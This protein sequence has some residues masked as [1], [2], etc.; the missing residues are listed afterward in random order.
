MKPTALVAA[1]LIL[2]AMP[3]GMA[4]AQISL[5]PAAEEGS[6]AVSYP[7]DGT[8]L[9]WKE[10]QQVQQYIAA[11]PNVFN[12]M[13][14]RKP[15]RWG[16]TVGT[17]RSWW[18]MDFQTS[19]NYQVASTCRAVG[20]NC[21]IFVEETQWGS[22]V[23]Q[24][25]VDSIRVAFDLRTPANA[26]KGVYQ[27]DVDA[28]GNPPDVDSDPKI[29]LLLLDIKDGYTGTG[30][31]IMGYFYSANEL[32]GG[33]SN[34]AEI[35]FLDV[36]PL[37]LSTA[38][39]LQGGMSTTAHEFQHMIHWNYNK[40]GDTF[41]NEGCSLLA[42]VNCGY[43]LYDQSGYIKETN[44]Y[45]FDWRTNDNTLV[46]HDYSRAA[47][48]FLYI[49]DQLGISFFKTLVSTAFTG[50]GRLDAAFSTFGT[51]LRFGDV[52]QNWLIANI[53]NDRSVD[54]KYGYLYP[55]VPKVAGTIYANPN[56]MVSAKNVANLG[57]EFPVFKY[58]SG[59]SINFST[60][61]AAVVV[62]AVE[63]GAAPTSTR[64]LNVTPGTLFTE[65][66]YGTTYPEVDFVVV[67]TDQYQ[68]YTYS[69]N[70]TGT[71]NSVELKW[72]LA[73]PAGYLKLSNSDTLCVTFDGLPGFKLD[74]IRV[75][76]RRAGSISGGIWRYSG[77]IGAPLGA[78]LA[79]PITATSD[80][81]PTVVDSSGPFPYPIPYP[82]WRLVDLRS[83]SIDAAS[84]FAAA[85]VITSTSV[86]IVV[87]KNPGSA[88]VH[89]V[90]Y[91]STLTPPGWYILTPPSGGDSIWAYGIRAYVS[92]RTTGVTEA[93]ELL[94]SALSVGQNYPNPF[95]PSTTIEYT[96]PKP[97]AVTI[98]VFD[99]L[100]RQIRL[101]ASGEQS[102]GRH[103]VVW[104][105][106]DNHGVD[107]MSGVYYY[108]VETA[109]GSISRK[110]MLVR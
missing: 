30:G 15:N 85:F 103:S 32:T 102:A 31:Y 56:E 94:P 105:G 84:P 5:A 43:P 97:G 19:T 108:R 73:E 22:R 75:A 33:Q 26:S 98:R 58:G 106:R 92:L 34:M 48:F 90:T 82:G 61:N 79:V 45:L 50:V 99:M 37:D 91:R 54:P 29:I 38:S 2:V 66:G 47:R 64:V 78:P 74:S 93:V 107:V 52:F 71:A 51:P 9:L 42:E 63:I 28:F 11:H 59:L 88:P 17:P 77:V 25:Q 3:A 24:P 7:I 21:Y 1:A 12:E 95:N 89:S 76:L 69:F 6:N 23:T 83:Y 70:S 39:G 16:F 96:L 46:L 18:A 86:P 20:T 60:N 68:N 40:F 81:T 13:R 53:L 57:A 49:R 87:I 41:T 14:L 100:G 4:F 110:M 72:D 104:D 109:S 65:P 8:P 27:M 101:L 10:D 62:K 80:I 67:N 55:N 36:N 44:H 35:Y